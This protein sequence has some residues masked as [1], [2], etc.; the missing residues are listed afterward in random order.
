MI[1]RNLLWCGAGQDPHQEL[2]G[3]WLLLEDGEENQVRYPGGGGTIEGGAPSGGWRKGK[4]YI[5]Y[6]YI[7]Y[8]HCRIALRGVYSTVTIV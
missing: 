3:V 6:E 2:R 5:K 7:Q 1:G 8:I 4:C